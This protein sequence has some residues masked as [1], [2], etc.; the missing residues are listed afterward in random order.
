M[1][2][3]EALD[4]DESLLELSTQAVFHLAGTPAQW[5][6]QPER[7][8][9]VE[10]RSFGCRLERVGEVAVDQLSREVHRKRC[11]WIDVGGDAF[12]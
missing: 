1:C 6:A 12:G 7:L 9:L 11:R 10:C 5:A 4:L 8:E 2:L 3:Y